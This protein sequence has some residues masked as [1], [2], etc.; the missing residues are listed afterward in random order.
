[1]VTGNSEFLLEKD[2]IVNME[3]AMK[4]A[5][6]EETKIKTKN[7]ISDIHSRIEDILYN[8]NLALE[9]DIS[10]ERLAKINNIVLEL[11]KSTINLGAAISRKTGRRKTRKILS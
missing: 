8:A 3:Q 9:D 1:M 2:E 6:D 7:N 10:T 11:E 4:E 5:V